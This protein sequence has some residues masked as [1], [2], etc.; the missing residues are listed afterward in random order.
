MEKGVTITNNST[1]S[2]T[3]RE[4]V[5]VRQGTRDYLARRL[6][7][8]IDKFRNFVDSQLLSELRPRDRSE[9]IFHRRSIKVG[10]VAN[11]AANGKWREIIKCS[12]KT[13][14]MPKR[15]QQDWPKSA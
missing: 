15:R 7:E 3:H 8:S 9:E 2:A 10:S 4:L 1:G 12:F 11:D 6:V 5:G 13:R 14:Q